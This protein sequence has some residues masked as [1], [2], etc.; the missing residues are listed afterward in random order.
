MGI[1]LATFT[2]L[3]AIS[4]GT[5]AQARSTP[6]GLWNFDDPGDLTHADVGSD[7]SLNGSHESVEGTGAGDGA[8]RIGVGSSYTCTHGIPANGGGALVNEYTLVMDVR[9]AGRGLWHCLFQTSPSNANDGDAFIDTPGRVGVSA[10]GYSFP[11]MLDADTWY[12]IVVVVDNGDRCEIYADGIRILDGSPQSIDGRFSL[13][14]TVFFFAD[15][16]GEDGEIDVSRIA[17]YAEAL[18]PED[19]AALGSLGGVGHFVTAAYLQNVKPGGISVMWETEAAEAGYVELGLDESYGTTEAGVGADSG[20]GTTISTAV[21]TGLTPG[22]TYHWRVVSGGAVTD[23]RTFVTAPEGRPDFSFVVWSD[24]QGYNGGDYLRDLTEPTRSMF[25]HMAESGVDLAVSCGDLAESGGSYTDTRVFYADRPVKILGASGVPFFN[26]WGNHDAGSTAV[27]RKYADFPSKDRGAPFH[28]GYGSY[29]FD[30]A[31]CHFICIDYQLESADIPGW[32][33]EDL[34]SP[35]AQSAKFTFVFV[36]RPPYCERWID[37]EASLRENLVPLMEEYGVDVCF[38]GHTHAYGRGFLNGVYYCITGGG[39]WLDHG[40]PLITDWP[41]MTVGGYH[42]IAPDIEGGLVHE[43]V[44]VDVEGGVATARMLAFHPDGTFREVLD[45]FT[46]EADQVGITEPDEHG[47]RLE[48]FPGAPNPFDREATIRFFVAGHAEER[49]PASLRIY[50][51]GG[52]LVRTLVD[53]DR[54][55]GRHEVLWDGKGDRGS[56]LTAGVY[57]CRLEAGGGSVRGKIVLVR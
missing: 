2:V 15:D 56:E 48:L 38:S 43:Y 32:V 18:T 21:V 47:T 12:R 14:P 17:L 35:S 5:C 7:L 1:R 16:N 26:A 52:R 9:T 44:R 45:T 8:A 46:M 50:D 27:I 39:S 23:D 24:S 34:Q 57:F 42:D 10:T 51:L 30:Y 55:P 4:A 53:G 40:E 3:L 41:H 6:V 29:S 11:R 33:E 22:T 49:V 31:G 20:N 28:A 36:H 25:R 13:D 54:G 19:A 37:G